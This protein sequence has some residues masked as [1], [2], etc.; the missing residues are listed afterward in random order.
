MNPR[1]FGRRLKPLAAK[2][3]MAMGQ[4]ALIEKA[5]AG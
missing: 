2:A 3:G 1:A 5:L 4:L